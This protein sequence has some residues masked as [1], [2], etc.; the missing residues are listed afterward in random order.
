M[1]RSSYNVA[2]LSQRMIDF[3]CLYINTMG[4][5]SIKHELFTESSRV[6][7]DTFVWMVCLGYLSCIL[8]AL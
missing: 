5:I 2:I 1:K 4:K 3:L 7:P 8:G 6:R